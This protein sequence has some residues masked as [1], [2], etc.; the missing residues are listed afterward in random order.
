MQFLTKT[1]IP[2][3]TI[4]S[5][6]K[7]HS[8][9]SAELQPSTSEI[10]LPSAEIQ[11]NNE[12][13]KQ[14]KKRSRNVEDTF[15]KYL[16]EATKNRKDQCNVVKDEHENFFDSMLPV[17]R[18]FSVDQTLAF[19]AEMINVIQ[20][21]K[22]G[23]MYPTDQFQQSQYEQFPNYYRFHHGTT[24]RTT[25]PAMSQMSNSSS[26]STLPPQVPLNQYEPNLNEY[27]LN[28]STFI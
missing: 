14:Q 16:E 2:R 25:S 26:I 28:N 1:I 3:Q 7:Q 13:K 20:K 18:Q 4:S 19:R 6:T 24:Q 8:E 12:F 22:R 10:N 21:I 9:E 15:M 23:T 27:T 11:N 5:I 17:V